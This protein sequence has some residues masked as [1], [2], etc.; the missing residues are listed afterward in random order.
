MF[1]HDLKNAPWDLLDISDDPNDMVYTWEN[2]FLEVLDR[3][4]PLRKTRVKNKL[5]PWLTPHIKKL[6]YKRDYLKKQSIKNKSKSYR[7]AYKAA[8]NQVNAEIK[9]AK[10]D[11]VTSEVDNDKSDSSRSWKAINMLLGRK[12]KVFGIN[13]LTVYQSVMTCPNLI[14]NAFNEHF[15]T[16][17]SKISSSVQNGSK[18]LETYVKPSK[19]KFEFSVITVD[20]FQNLLDTLSVSK[21]SGLDKISARMLKYAGPVISLPLSYI[22]NKSIASGIFPDNWKNAKV[23]PVYKGNSRND[24]NNYRPISVLPVVAKVFEKLVFEQLYS[25]FTKNDILSKFQSGF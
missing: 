14:A 5:S 3:H 7:E 9:K 25:Y 12:S 22:F 18:P 16:I 21:S 8:R 15:S 17:G 20:T 11:Y 23:F 1:I 4:A 13:E 2:L 6:M 10:I 19:S 24:P